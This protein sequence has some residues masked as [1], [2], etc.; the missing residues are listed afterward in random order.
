MPALQLPCF[1]DVDLE[2]LDE[3][4]QILAPI[5]VALDRLQGEKDAYY[6]TLMPTL[7]TL[8]V[9]QRL[10]C[11]TPSATGS[12]LSQTLHSTTKFELEALNFLEEPRKDIDVLRSYPTIKQLFVRFNAV[13]PSSAAVERLFSFAGIITRPHRR[14]MGDKTFEKLLLLKEH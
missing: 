11:S 9:K 14:N 12:N 3:Y 8:G 10:H 6:A 7:F 5:A 2:F 13:L 1:K 4:C